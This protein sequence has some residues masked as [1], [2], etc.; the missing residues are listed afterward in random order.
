MMLRPKLLTA[1]SRDPF[2][3]PDRLTPNL[4]S[5][6]TDGIQPSH[7]TM[8]SPALCAILDAHGDQI[9]GIA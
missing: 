6:P 8:V 7:W 1:F 5:I 9:C 2:P 4:G 3:T